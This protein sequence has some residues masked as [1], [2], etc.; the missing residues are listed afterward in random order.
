MY[1]EACTPMS[2]RSDSSRLPPILREGSGLALSPIQIEEVM[3]RIY[4]RGNWL[5]KRFI[6]GHL[7][8]A[9]VLSTA[10]KTWAATAVVGLFAFLLFFIPV[11]F[12]PRSSIT[13]VLCGISLQ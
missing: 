3:A 5:M 13:R 2:N 8:M 11:T 12:L 1:D 9:L 10:Y 7:L 4:E 6:L